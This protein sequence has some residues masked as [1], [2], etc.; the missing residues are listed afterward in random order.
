MCFNDKGKAGVSALVMNGLASTLNIHNEEGEKAIGLSSLI[1]QD[2]NFLSV[3][4][5]AGKN[6]IELL[7]DR[8]GARM[9]IYD[10]AGNKSWEAP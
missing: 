9:R 1:E 10:K 8:T 2:S 4:D 5:K 6:V 3:Q 7:S